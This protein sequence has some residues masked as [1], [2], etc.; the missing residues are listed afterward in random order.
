MHDKPHEHYTRPRPQR[1]YPAGYDPDDI[2]AVF[3]G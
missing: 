2:K 1:S 3:G